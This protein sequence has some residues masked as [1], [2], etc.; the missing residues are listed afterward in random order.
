VYDT[1]HY[2]V[3]H[4]SLKGPVLLYLKKQHFRHHYQD[5]TR[6]FG[7]SSPLWDFMLGTYGRTGK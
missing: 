2:A 5:S 3:H 4:F 7:V 1:V 6:D